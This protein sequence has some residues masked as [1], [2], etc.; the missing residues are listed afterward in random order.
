MANVSFERKVGK[1]GSKKISTP[2]VIKVDGQERSIAVCRPRLIRSTDDSSFFEAPQLITL[3]ETGNCDDAPMKNRPSSNDQPQQKS[4]EAGT[5]RKRL[6]HS[7]DD[8][9]IEIVQEIIPTRK[10]PSRRVKMKTSTPNSTKATRCFPRIPLKK[11]RK[12][13]N[14]GKAPSAP[15]KNSEG[16]QFNPNRPMDFQFNRRVMTRP[17]NS[18]VRFGNCFGTTSGESPSMSTNRGYGL[19]QSHFQ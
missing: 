7:S 18:P 1:L 11:L 6:S 5:K 19:C 8:D 2:I 13:R 12:K 9:V 16:Y 14:K 3:D 10:T 15:I 17:T 4:A